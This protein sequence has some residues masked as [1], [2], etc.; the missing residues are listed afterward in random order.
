MFSSF[1]NNFKTKI[2]NVDWIIILLI[3][4]IGTISLFTIYSID[5]DQNNYFEKHFARFIISFLL[6]LFVAIINIKFWL[7]FSYVFYAFVIFLLI[8]VDYF[9]LSAQ[10]A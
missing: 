5:T 4:L 8:L 6:L 9:G 10:G 7:R 2:V 3:L 1:Q